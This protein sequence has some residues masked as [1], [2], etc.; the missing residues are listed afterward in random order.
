MISLTSLVCAIQPAYR[1]HD[2]GALEGPNQFDFGI[3]ASGELTGYTYQFNS[4]QRAFLYC[5]GAFTN[6]GTLGGFTSAG[7]EISDRR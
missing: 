7:H 1:L 3:N 4:M 2:V 6:I 5:A